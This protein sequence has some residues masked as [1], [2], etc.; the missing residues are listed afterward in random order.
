M[1]IKNGMPS[2]VQATG[3]PFEKLCMFSWKDLQKQ[4]D[5]T[6]III[7]LSKLNLCHSFAAVTV[8]GPKPANHKVNRMLMT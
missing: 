2:V 8:I 3:L 4:N 5:F 1:T 7:L 6:L